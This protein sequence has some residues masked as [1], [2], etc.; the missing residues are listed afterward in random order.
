MSIAFLQIGQPPNTALVRTEQRL[1]VSVQGYLPP[2]N[3][4]DY[5]AVNMTS[6]FGAFVFQR[7]VNFCQYEVITF[8]Q[9]IYLVDFKCKSKWI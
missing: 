6:R 2:H 5:E 4:T 1:S 7:S 3:F 9:S 8:S